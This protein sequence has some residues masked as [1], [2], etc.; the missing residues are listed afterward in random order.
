MCGIVGYIGDRSAVG[1]ILDHPFRMAKPEKEALDHI[2]DTNE[3]AGHVV[4]HGVNLSLGGEF[5]VETF[6]CGH[7]PL[8]VELRR[9]WRQGVVV[10]LAAGNEG[11]AF[12]ADTMKSEMRGTISDLKRDPLNT[13]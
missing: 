2:F 12:A 13:P 11:F 5:D 1:I 6:N 4:I 8:C 3:R 10:V 7:T 9:L